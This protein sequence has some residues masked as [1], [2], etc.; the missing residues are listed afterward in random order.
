[1]SSFF[2]SFHRADRALFLLFLLILPLRFTRFLPFLLLLFLPNAPFMLI[3]PAVWKYFADSCVYHRTFTNVS[4]ADGICWFTF[5]PLKTT[6]E[7]TIKMYSYR[8]YFVLFYT[9]IWIYTTGRGDLV[10]FCD[11]L[12]FAVTHHCTRLAFFFSRFLCRT[13]QNRN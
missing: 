9:R 11:K 10:C 1:M 13:K 4:V 3:A 7:S 5:L 12:D 8:I 2:A 6:S